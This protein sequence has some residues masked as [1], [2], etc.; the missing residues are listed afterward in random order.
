MAANQESSIA[1]T[2]AKELAPDFYQPGR[3]KQGWGGRNSPRVG[4][5]PHVLQGGDAYVVLQMLVSLESM[6]VVQTG[7]EMIQG[8]SRRAHIVISM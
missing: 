2:L 3:A 6:G 8:F 7:D 1:R 4:P 5:F